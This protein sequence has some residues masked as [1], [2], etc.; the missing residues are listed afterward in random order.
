MKAVVIG[1]RDGA[2]A[3]LVCLR[4]ELDRMRR[5]IQK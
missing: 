2:V 1:Q 5:T 3:Q 4:R